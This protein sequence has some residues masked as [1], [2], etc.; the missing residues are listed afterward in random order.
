MNNEQIL[1]K[2]V[3]FDIISVITIW[4]FFNNLYVNIR[5]GNKTY[6]IYPVYTNII[7]FV[8]SIFILR[9]YI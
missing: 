8:I 1:I 7:N 4:G 9:K 2:N 6:P 5:F 3:A